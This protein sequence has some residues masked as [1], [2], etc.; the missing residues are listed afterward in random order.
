MKVPA[1]SCRSKNRRDMAEGPS[2]SSPCTRPVPT[3]VGPPEAL[4]ATALG[5]VTGIRSG[6]A[7][8]MWCHPF[9]PGGN[10]SRENSVDGQIDMVMGRIGMRMKRGK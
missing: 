3:M 6:A 2:N 10:A 5:R 4:F 7:N 1:W 8:W 9:E